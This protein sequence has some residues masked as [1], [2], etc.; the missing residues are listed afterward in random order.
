MSPNQQAKHSSPYFITAIS[1]GA[2]QA[3]TNRLQST[4]KIGLPVRFV[5]SSTLLLQIL[6]TLKYLDYL[7]NYLIY[8]YSAV[9]TKHD[10]FTKQFSQFAMYI[11]IIKAIY[12]DLFLFKVPLP[13]M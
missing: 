13:S 10:Q 6:T 8:M 1:S 12:L 2:P 9:A 7:R 3:K 4:A 11:S 5:N